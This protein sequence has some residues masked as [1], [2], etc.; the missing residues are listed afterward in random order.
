[1][2]EVQP[3][4]DFQRAYLRRWR[5]LGPIL[6]ALQHEDLRR[7]TDA[8]YF[9][10]MEQLWSIPVESEPRRSS[11]LVEWQRLLRR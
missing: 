2:S 6:D 1:M 7:M 11:G 10:L 8:D 3:N 9:R 4:I 5:R